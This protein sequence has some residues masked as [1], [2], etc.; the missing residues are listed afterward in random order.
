MIR[1]TFLLL[2]LVPFLVLAVVT[3]ALAATL[4]C[5]SGCSCLLPAKAK[6]LGYSTY[7]GGNQVV[8]GYDTA[9]NPMYCY[10]MPKTIAPTTTALP[11]C[12]TGCLCLNAADAKAKGYMAY[13]GGKQ[14]FCGYDSQQNLQY[15]YEPSVTTT[16]T[17]VQYIQCPADSV[18]VSLKQ[19]ELQNLEKTP[20]I[21]GPCG[22]SVQD[23]MA[24]SCYQIQK[25]TTT[26]P[27]PFQPAITQTPLT[28]PPTT[29]PLQPRKYIQCQPPCMCM[30]PAE[31]AQWEIDRCE[32]AVDACG[33][34]EVYRDTMYCYAALF[35]GVV[36]AN[37]IAGPERTASIPDAVPCK[38][39]YICLDESTIREKGYS[40]YLGRQTICGYTTAQGPLYCAH[41]LNG[42]EPQSMPPREAE[43][44]LPAKIWN[45]MVRLFTQRSEPAP[46]AQPLA[47]VNYCEL[48]Y[49]L[50]SCSGQCVNL[51]TDQDNCGECGNACSSSQFC[52]HG[53]CVYHYGTGDCGPLAPMVCEGICVDPMHDSNNCG[54]CGYRCDPGETCCGGSCVD[55]VNDFQHC[56]ECNH[57]CPYP[58]TCRHGYCVDILTDE[59][60]CGS[61]DEYCDDNQICCAGR[62][63]NW[64]TD[65]DNCGGC[66]NACGRG[67]QCCYGSCIDPATFATDRYNCGSCENQC[68]MHEDCYEPRWP[69]AESSWVCDEH[70]QETCC[71]GE[72]IDVNALGWPIDVDNCGSCGNEC[73][74][75]SPCDDGWCWW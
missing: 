31:A 39:G 27:T 35:P 68:W 63:V 9:K 54:V 24:M 51:S 29:L 13:C 75:L 2:V 41:P 49:E 70:W 62:C 43:P 5:P 8:C 48:R 66:G 16:S 12:S 36:D 6:E 73:G 40:L 17:P 23:Q 18:C 7:C 3:P 4:G 52:I 1:R 19:A 11:T 38:S 30:A 72:C 65:E 60:H 71:S 46:S 45:Y 47:P 69:G 61:S 20:N 50:D 44:A 32:G 10:T 55:T 37:G 25:A 34:S 28:T 33:Y 58:D 14:T 53:S 15:C 59:Y 42:G 56:G 64:S 26:P 74:W 22:Y 57:Q 21:P 67:D